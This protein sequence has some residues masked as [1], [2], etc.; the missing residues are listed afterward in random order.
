MQKGWLLIGRNA[1]L[2]YLACELHICIILQL[3]LIN[4]IAICKNEFA[5]G[6]L[7]KQIIL[8]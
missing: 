6:I 7:L 4:T 1:V 8:L 2:T 5:R 3:F